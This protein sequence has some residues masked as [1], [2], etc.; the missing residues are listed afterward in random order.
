MTKY[1]S[2]VWLLIPIERLLKS[3]EAH[4]VMQ[5]M[6]RC[7]L[8]CWRGQDDSINLE[9]ENIEDKQTDVITKYNQAME[10]LSAAAGVESSLPLTHQ[11][12]NWTTAS[13]KEKKC[14]H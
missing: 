9:A 4:C 6:I 1:D 10:C 8:G 13:E 12:F 2:S 3:A 11:T 5:K 14:V 7:G